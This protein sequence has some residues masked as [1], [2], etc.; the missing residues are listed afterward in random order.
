MFHW[1]HENR[2]IHEVSNIPRG[3]QLSFHEQA[4]VEALNHAGWSA[5]RIAAHL[6]RSKTVIANYIRCPASYGTEK[7]SGRPNIVTPIS[8]RGIIRSISN[9]AKSDSEV[10][11]V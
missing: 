9:T 6:G 1:K 8:K 3:T 7:R 10:T 2:F 4:Q 5:R 11:K